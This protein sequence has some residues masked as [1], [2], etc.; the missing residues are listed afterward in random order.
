VAKYFEPEYKIKIGKQ[1][2]H[3]IPQVYLRQ[4]GFQKFGTKWFV[5]V[6]NIEK[7]KWEDRE[8]RRFLGEKEIY[9]FE[10][11]DEISEMI[12]E[13]KLNGGIEN[14]IRLIIEELECE[15]FIHENTH[16]AI[17]ETTANF[18]CRNLEIRSW[19]EGWLNKP[20][21]KEFFDFINKVTPFE[22]DAKQRVFDNI[23]QF[24]I[25]DRVNAYMVFF[26]N[27]VA[28]LLRT[29]SIEVLIGGEDYPFFTS[30]NPVC[31]E[32][33]EG[34]GDLEKDEMEVYFPVSNKYLVRFYWHPNGSDIQRNFKVVTND[35][36]NHFHK[37]ILPSFAKNFIIC[38]KSM[39]EI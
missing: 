30:D 27:Y 8:I 32:G 31:I 16:L 7:D 9:T 33:V 14:R 10:F 2:Q 12:I 24:P 20:N 35:I 19:I 38:P 25:K 36:Y 37:N 18:L 28:Y 39:E 29:A 22:E 34:Y 17:A 4:F 1:Y 26:M 21:L 5:S 23:N 3:I 6:R 15:D 11:A 13:N